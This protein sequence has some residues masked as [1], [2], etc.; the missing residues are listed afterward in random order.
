MKG[1]K[2]TQSAS[3]PHCNRQSPDFSISILSASG[4]TP[5]IPALLGTCVLMEN[6]EIVMGYHTPDPSGG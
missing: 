5:A 4:Q 1:H 6:V 3:Q 2:T